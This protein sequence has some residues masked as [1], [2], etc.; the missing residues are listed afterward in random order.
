MKHCCHYQLHT[1]DAPRA[2]AALHCTKHSTAQHNT[3]YQRA[4]RLLLVA[5]AA[6]RACLDAAR[7]V[8]AGLAGFAAALPRRLR[9]ARGGVGSEGGMSSSS[10]SPPVSSGESR[11]LSRLSADSF[12]VSAWGTGD[13]A[14]RNGELAGL[15]GAAG[16]APTSPSESSAY[17]PACTLRADERDDLAN[18]NTHMRAHTETETQ[19][20]T[21]TQ[22]HTPHAQTHESES[23]APPLGCING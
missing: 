8:A 23:E 19:T 9:V 14:L 13:D 6:G 3:A 10:S 1:Y 18:D 17:M 2:A 22:T 15:R 5:R 16:A 7:L 21:D 12:A 11:P 20:H 4:R